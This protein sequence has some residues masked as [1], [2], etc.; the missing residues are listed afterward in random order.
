MKLEGARDYL[1]AHTTHSRPMACRVHG[2]HFLSTRTRM[3]SVASDAC[4]ELAWDMGFAQ[5]HSSLTNSYGNTL[6]KVPLLS[7]FTLVLCFT[8]LLLIKTPSSP[9]DR[10]KSIL[11]SCIFHQSDGF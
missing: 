5:N 10:G 4:Q 7:S 9:S 6:P 8:L 2:T 1:R 11:S 3:P